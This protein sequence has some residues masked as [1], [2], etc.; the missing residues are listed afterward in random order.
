MSKT[1]KWTLALLL[2]ALAVTACAVTGLRLYRA[3]EYQRALD[4]AQSLYAAGDYTGAQAAFEAL[5]LT[6]RAADCALQLELLDK[7][8]RLRQAEALLEAGDY[9]A[10]REAFLALGDFE[11]AAE[12]I[13][14]CELG[15]A[16]Q[17]LAEGRTDE[18]LALLEKLG[19]YP[20]SAELMEQIRA[21]QYTEALAAT[22]ACRMDEAISLWNRLGDYRDASLLLQRCLDH[23]A[24]A[25]AGP[26]EPIQESSYYGR[27]NRTGKVYTCRL[28][29][30]YVP[31]D[32][33]PETGSLIF[34]PGGYDEVLANNYLTEYVDYTELPN[35]I[36]L[37]CYANGYSDPDYKIEDC[38]KMLEQAA[39]ENHVF[40][41]DLVLG[42]A[43]MGAY[44]AI[45]GAAEIYRDHG[46]AAKAV[47]TFD[48][49]NHWEEKSR[50]MSPEQCDEAAKAG[51]AYYLLEFGGI[52][53][54]KRPIELMVVHGVNVTIVEVKEGGHYS[55]ITE[56]MREGMI[57]WALGQGER[58]DTWNYRYIPLDRNS[59]YPRGSS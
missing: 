7:G 14:A 47:L 57:D 11:N 6:E 5:G 44:T 28:G 51:T 12:R 53:M 39:I 49:G 23:V 42:G 59:T 34:W 26:D 32:A 56:A 35:A 22:Y 16:G 43:S 40:L 13:P 4:E 3:K 20:G 2:L 54:N 15:E 45:Q 25:A 58:P 18:A 27:N 29:L 52:G 31:N 9:A 10:A 46:L 19:D 17:L 48:A 41:H 8:E 38:Y 30:L 36:M 33:G 50:I 55:I 21:A 1:V 37:L 24:A